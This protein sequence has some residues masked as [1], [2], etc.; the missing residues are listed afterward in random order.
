MAGSIIIINDRTK[1]HGK[2]RVMQW[3]ANHITMAPNLSRRLHF[4]TS[5]L[6]KLL[7]P[8]DSV[9]MSASAKGPDLM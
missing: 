3:L 4:K 2:L 6:L 7:P 9:K 1:T 5:A 8:F